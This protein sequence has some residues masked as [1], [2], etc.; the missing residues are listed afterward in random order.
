MSGNNEGTP[1]PLNPGFGYPGAG[2]PRS[3]MPTSDADA[4]VDP[5]VEALN[6]SAEYN[7]IYTLPFGL[8]FLLIPRDKNF[9]LSHNN[10][11]FLTKTY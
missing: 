10:L 3:E 5:M 4:P 1:N 9:L 7:I 6:G 2:T 11:Y 8:V